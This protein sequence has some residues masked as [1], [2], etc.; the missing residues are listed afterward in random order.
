MSETAHFL[1]TLNKQIEVFKT[2]CET[3]NKNHDVVYNLIRNILESLAG[4]FDSIGLEEKSVDIRKMAEFL[5]K[6]VVSG[7]QSI[8]LMILIHLESF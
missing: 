6:I 7:I 5:T 4:L 3:G 2:Q 8:L 1:Q